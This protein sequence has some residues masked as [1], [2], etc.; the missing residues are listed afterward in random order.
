MILY[1]YITRSLHYRCSFKIKLNSKLCFTW[2]TRSRIRR[3]VSCPFNFAFK[4][5]V[6]NR[7]LRPVTGVKLNAGCFNTLRFE[8]QRFFPRNGLIPP[9]SLYT[10]HRIL[11]LLPTFNL[12]AQNTNNVRYAS[13]VSG[14]EMIRSEIRSPG[15]FR[16]PFQA[17]SRLKWSLS[18][19]NNNKEKL[20]LSVF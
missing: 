7:S 9:P 10:V 3:S 4:P 6:T 2:N 13:D 18:V 11:I 1:Y 17:Q 15:L 8:R 16:D 14:Y 12:T 5:G 20:N 19:K